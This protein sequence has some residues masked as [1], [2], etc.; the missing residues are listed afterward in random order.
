MCML[1]AIIKIMTEIIQERIKEN[2]E[3]YTKRG[4][5]YNLHPVAQIKVLIPASIHLHQ[6]RNSDITYCI[7]G[8][9]S[10]KFEV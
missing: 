3:T 4:Q 8:K 9:I 6:F 1:P 2:H 10:E 5:A 7:C